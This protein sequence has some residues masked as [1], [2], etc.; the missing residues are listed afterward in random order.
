MSPRWTSFTAVNKV[1]G[2]ELHATTLHDDVTRP[3]N[4]RNNPRFMVEYLELRRPSFFADISSFY[5]F[6]DHKQHRVQ[7]APINKVEES[8]TMDSQG[9]DHVDHDEA[10]TGNHIDSAESMRYLELH[11]WLLTN[12]SFARRHNRK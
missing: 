12:S 9:T 3:G 5:S 8:D 4:R 7:S 6:V 2:G 10:H 1:P 11:Q